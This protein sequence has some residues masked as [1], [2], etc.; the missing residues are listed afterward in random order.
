MPRTKRPRMDTI[1]MK[2]FLAF[3]LVGAILFDLGAHPAAASDALPGQT[4]QIDGG[5]CFQTQALMLKVISAIFAPKN[6]GK[7]IA[8]GKIAS[9]RLSKKADDSPFQELLLWMRQHLESDK[10]VVFENYAS[11]IEALNQQASLP[12]ASLLKEQP[13]PFKRIP[14]EKDP[15][16]DNPVKEDEALADLSVKAQSN[17]KIEIWNPGTDQS[18]WVTAPHLQKEIKCRKIIGI[19]VP[20][21]DGHIFYVINPQ[22]SKVPRKRQGW[23]DPLLLGAI[24]AAVVLLVI[25]LTASS[26][27]SRIVANVLMSTSLLFGMP[28]SHPRA[29]IPGHSRLFWENLDV[30]NWPPQAVELFTTLKRIDY[31]FHHLPPEK[32]ADARKELDQANQVFFESPDLNKNRWLAKV[33]IAVT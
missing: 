9:E 3:I 23:I 11:A 31:V 27:H 7:K 8:Y 15:F 10:P 26:S 28:W 18:T 32:F 25:G 6:K 16:F 30:S 21:I 17:E 5:A 24:A 1:P 22:P 14:P 19:R 33:L 13:R 12:K 4:S 2:R 29:E 20:L